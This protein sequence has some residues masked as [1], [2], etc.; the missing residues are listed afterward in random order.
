M[1]SSKKRP[2]ETPEKNKNS[3]RLHT[4]HM[5]KRR[6]NEAGNVVDVSLQK[7]FDRANHPTYYYEKE[8]EEWRKSAVA[9]MLKT[10][11]GVWRKKFKEP[12]AEDTEMI[13][14]VIKNL[15]NKIKDVNNNVDMVKDYRTTDERKKKAWV[16]Y[17]FFRQG[18]TEYKRRGKEY[19]GKLK[20]LKQENYNESDGEVGREKIRGAEEA[21]NIIYTDKGLQ[22]RP[23]G[24]G[25]KSPIPWVAAVDIDTGSLLDEGFE[26]NDEEFNKMMFE[27]WGGRRKKKYTKRK[28]R[29][30]GTKK[31]RRKRN[32]KKRTRRRRRK[33]KRR[34][35]R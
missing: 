29:R 5:K 10:F 16:T 7:R 15:M 22:K 31:K 34:R 3:T 12:D 23:G 32:L 6:R 11:G 28:R 13:R 21:R 27:R 17:T 20:R 9:N 2:P 18:I 1:S 30:R 24:D 25:K 19:I 14:L 4:E 8:I 33:S 26:M 35:R